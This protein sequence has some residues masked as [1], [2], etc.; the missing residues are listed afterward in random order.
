MIAAVMDDYYESVKKCVRNIRG[1][2]IRIVFCLE[3][4]C[5]RYAIGKCVRSI[6]VI[7]TR[8]GGLL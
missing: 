7:D 1:I 4:V 6:R 3:Y 8:I 2:E 5:C